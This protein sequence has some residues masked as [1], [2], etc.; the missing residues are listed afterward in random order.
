MKPYKKA[1]EDLLSKGISLVTYWCGLRH[2][3]TDIIEHA[4]FNNYKYSGIISGDRAV[5]IVNDYGMK[6]K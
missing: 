4:D 3:E 2:R 6:T 5:L 1:V